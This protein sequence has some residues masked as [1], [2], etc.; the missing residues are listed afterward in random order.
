MIEIKNKKIYKDG[1]PFRSITGDLNG[2][3]TEIR[4]AS[5]ISGAQHPWTTFGQ[6]KLNP[7]FEGKF[8]GTLKSLKGKA[9]LAG[10]FSGKLLTRASRGRDARGATVWSPGHGAPG[11]N[12]DAVQ[13]NFF[14]MEGREYRP[15][16]R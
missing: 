1:K 8:M 6:K 4:F 13:A 10:V 16:L 2:C 5:G 7:G 3:N 11:S 9:L 15:E 14:K 12:N